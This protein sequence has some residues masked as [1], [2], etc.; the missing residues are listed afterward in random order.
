MKRT[1]K[2]FLVLCSLFSAVSMMAQTSV[3]NVRPGETFTSIAARYGVDVNALIEANPYTQKCHVGAQLVIPLVQGSTSEDASTPQESST[4]SS[5]KTVASV[6]A[7]TKTKPST[8]PEAKPVDPYQLLYDGVKNLKS[9]KYSTARKLFT[10]ALKIKNIPEAYYYRGL[11]NYKSYK[12]KP[13]YKDLGIAK[14]SSKLDEKMKADASELYTYAYKK[15]QEKVENRREIWAEIG[16]TVGTTLLAVG[17]VAAGV[18]SETM[19]ASSGYG[20]AYSS[21]YGSASAFYSPSG[22]S[23]TIFPSGISSMSTSQF[24]SYLDNQLTDLFYMTAMQVEQQ[25][26][27]EYMQ[28]TNGGQTMTYD[29]Y[30]NIKA[31]SMMSTPSTGSYGIDA[32]SS[33]QTDYQQRKRDILNSTVGETCNHCKGTGKCPACNGTKVASGMGLTY[34]CTV[35]NENG[36]CPV[37]HGT[38]VTSW[39]R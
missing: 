28:A 8:K 35:C 24:N 11:C 27:S 38:K 15:H 29:Q 32:G 9:G 33:N 26:M 36:D 37:C 5:T 10:K 17:T 18:V 21:G 2:L 31:Q 14:R 3:H 25:N 6:D 20:S 23:G 13:A 19:A 34:E 16:R 4:P 22:S 30:M 12:W 1:L 39:N 7:K